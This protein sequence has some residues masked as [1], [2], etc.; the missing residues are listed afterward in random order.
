MLILFD[1]DG[2]LLKT[3]GAGLR[4]MSKALSD[5]H[6]PHE[7]GTYDLAGIDTSG[8]LDSHIWRDLSR[9]H[10]LPHDEATHERFRERY[11]HHLGEG[12]AGDSVSEALTGARELVERLHPEP[13]LTL[14]LLTGNYATTGRLKVASA[15]FD[16]DRFVV[17]AFAD[18]GPDRRSLPPVAIDR[19]RE[20]HGRPVAPESV[21]IVGDTPHDVDCAVHNGCACLAVTTGRHPADE[22][23]GADRI[24]DSLEAIEDLAGWIL[25]RRAD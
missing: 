5:L 7:S 6:G 14:G 3:H 1:I 20:R 25:S 8:R 10:D 13:E 17:N 11:R 21:L 22:L 9:K 18:D 12:F 19:Y 23:A 16:P 4:A 2:T 24:V 15:G